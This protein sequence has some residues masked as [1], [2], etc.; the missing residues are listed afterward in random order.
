[1]EAIDQTA[2]DIAN[3]AKAELDSHESQCVLR[4]DGINAKL[5]LI[6]NVLGWGGGGL[7]AVL[8]SVVGFLGA[9]EIRASGDTNKALQSQIILMSQRMVATPA[10]QPVPVQ[11]PA[12]APATPTYPEP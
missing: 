12:A 6:I 10:P 3:Q 2:R 9:M 1:M 4:Y 7:V 11:P 8:L 5:A